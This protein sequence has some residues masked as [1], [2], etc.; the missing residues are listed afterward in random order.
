MMEFIR[1]GGEFMYVILGLSVF[2]LAIAIEKY[3]SFYVSY[4]YDEGFFQLIL[5]HAKSGDLRSAGG[6]CYNTSHPLAKILLVMLNHHQSTKEALESVI[7]IEVKK[8]VPKIQRRT[9]YLQMIGNI[10]TLVG[11]LGTIQ[12]LILS[13]KSLAGATAATKAELLAAG[14]STAMN[15]TAFGLIV[16][17]PSVVCYTNLSNK[18]SQILQKYEETISELLHILIY[19]QKNRRRDRAA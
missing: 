16:A 9:G 2:A 8:L 6:L 4:R 13:F 11:L 1:S 15:T 18:E 17:I 5:Q 10:A 12:G 3:Y 7:G 14:I 19:K